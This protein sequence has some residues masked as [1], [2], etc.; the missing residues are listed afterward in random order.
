M[1]FRFSEPYTEQGMK[2]LT[3]PVM[4]SA[5]L[6]GIACRYD[7]NSRPDFDLIS[8]L[9]GLYIV[10]VCPEQLGGLPTPRPP[11]EIR[12]GDGFD[13]LEES[14]G[15]F[16]RTNSRQMAGRDVTSQFV[17]GAQE[18]FKLADMLG[19]RQC[20]LKGRSPSCGLTPVAGV[21]AARLIMAGI[22]VTEAG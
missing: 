8:R 20:Y 4:V 13:V 12:G 18:C 5:C 10:P 22:K 16:V 9:A 6:L 14:A 21:T 2:P 3:S 15:V 19:I 7:G 11:A 1:G 17:R